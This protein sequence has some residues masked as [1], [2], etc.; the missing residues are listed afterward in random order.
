M[1]LNHGKR[2]TAAQRAVSG[3]AILAAGVTGVTSVDATAGAS[4]RSEAAATSAV[5]KQAVFFDTSQLTPEMTDPGRVVGPPAAYL[6]DGTGHSYAVIRSQSSPEIDFWT[7]P[8]G[9]ERFTKHRVATLHPSPFS[10]ELAAMALASDP[11]GS[12]LDLAATCVNVKGHPQG[13]YVLQKQRSDASFP[14]ATGKDLIATSNCDQLFTDSLPATPAASPN[15]ASC[16][17]ESNDP[18]CKRLLRLGGLV[19]LP[20]R[21]VGVMYERRASDGDHLIYATGKPGH[22]FHRTTVLT[23]A[24]PPG[25]RPESPLGFGLARDASNGRLVAFGAL[26]GVAGLVMLFKNR[27]HAW[28]APVA[29]ET[30][31]G[32]TLNGGSLVAAKGAIWIATCCSFHHPRRPEGVFIEHRSPSGHWRVSHRV[33][34]TNGSSKGDALAIDPHN[35]V[36]GLLVAGFSGLHYLRH[37]PGG[38]WTRQRVSRDHA[39]FPIALFLTPSAKQFRIACFC[40]KPPIKG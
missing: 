18:Q 22:R 4:P 21:R 32:S 13:L 14:A 29:P 16:I 11:R 3:L 40:I 38:T 2:V 28:S 23:Q 25:A 27:A 30:A 33:P 17:P 5:T 7:R 1:R 10:E 26:P 19:A 9:I 8:H 20:H 37:A 39:D 6:R 12:T 34:G 36:V 15:S 24:Y 35:G 31:G